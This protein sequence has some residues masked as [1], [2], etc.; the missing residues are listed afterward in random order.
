MVKNVKILW[1]YSP[2]RGTI[3]SKRCKTDIVDAFHDG[4][5]RDEA[6]NVTESNPCIRLKV[7]A[8]SGGNAS[9]Q[10]TITIT[11]QNDRFTFKVID[12]NSNFPI[13]VKEYEVIVT[14]EED[15]RSYVDIRTNIINRHEF[16]LLDRIN[17]DSEES[18]AIAA[19]QTFNAPCPTWLGITRD[20]RI[21]EVGFRG[22]HTDE[23]H[24]MNEWDY[25]KPRYNYETTKIDGQ[26]II[27]LKYDYMVGRGLG[28]TYNIHRSLEKGHLPILNSRLEDGGIEYTSKMFCTLENKPLKKGNIQ[29]THYLIAD[30]NS[31]GH[32]FTPQQEQEKESIL[33]KEMAISEEIVLYINISA[34]NSSNAPKYA[35]MRIPQ[36]NVSTMPEVSALKTVYDNSTGYGIIDENKIFLVALMDGKPI[37]QV[38]TAVLVPSGESVE[39]LFIIPHS[40]VDAVRADALKGKNHSVLLEECIEFWEKQS[41]NLMKVDLPEKRIENM[42][43]AGIYH[44]DLLCFGK[45]PDEPV[46]PAIGVYSP[47]GS[48]SSPIIQYFDSCGYTEISKRSLEYFF[49]KQH[50]DGFMQNFGGYMLENGAVLWTAYLHFLYTN[51]YNWLKEKE[52]Q[53]NLSCEFLFAWIEK[54]STDEFRDK[55]FGLIDGKVADPEDCY[56]SYMLNAYAY[57]GLFG[58][59]VMLKKIGSVHY[60]KVHQ[61]TSALKNNIEKAISKSISESPVIPLGNGQWCPSISPW[62]EY[63]GPLSLYA[64]GGSAHTH[65]SPVLRD[66][67][68]GS[69][70]LIFLNVVKKDAIIS[71]FIMN[72]FSELFYERHVAFSQ[73]FYSQHAI[74]HLFRNEKKAF[75]KEFYN[76]FASLADRETYTFWEH[77]FLATPHKTHEEAWFLMKCRYMLYLEETSNYNEPTL[78][79]MP[80]VPSQWLL[81]GKDISVVN[82]NTY[83][84]MLSYHLHHVIINDKI[85]LLIRMELRECNQL[86]III[87]LPLAE[88]DMINESSNGKISENRKE[89]IIDTFKTEQTLHITVR[90]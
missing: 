4:K 60:L 84:G 25:I 23:A 65:G 6:F 53:I 31:Y 18:Y 54:N 29:G 12:V 10:S 9:N 51:D 47:I 26:K 90:H 16:S 72:C 33:S 75:L 27:A 76:S 15:T 11:T 3:E 66:A 24:Y 44:L 22:T 82:A 40:P 20:I 37:E 73:P 38:E 42:M 57:A 61:A 80:G 89:I 2:I 35:W 58:A 63:R 8:I 56:H 64:D 67:L 87:R 46:A 86:R 83:Y 79:L 88:N 41:E 1:G 36:P 74:I 85:T 70:Y 78:I 32:M 19:S 17:M 81:S 48:E 49:E 77:Y 52:S 45:E 14:E 28:C 68:I 62:V 34:K 59:S 43:K 5:A 21:F 55:G 30:A 7:S 69:I 39:Y 71:D 13:Y 50:E